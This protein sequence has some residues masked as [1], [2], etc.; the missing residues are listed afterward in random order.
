MTTER[1]RIDVEGVVQGVGF[2]PFVYRLARERGL[3]GWV[4]N[5]PAGVGIEVQG[6]RR[7]IRDFLQQL[8]A[9]RP[10]Q[11]EIHRISHHTTATEAPTGF[12]IRHSSAG[13]MPTASVPV[14]L[15]P[16]ADCLRELH[17]P[18]DRRYRY[19]FI[20][21]TQCGPRFSIIRQLPYDR[22]N[23]AMAGFALCAPCRADYEDPAN[24]RFHAEP[25]ACPDCGP[26]LA[27]L[28]CRGARQASGEAALET[29]AA[30]L[31]AGRI[32]ALKG[33]GGFQPAPGA[34]AS[35]QRPRQ[36]C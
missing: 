1:C 11:A 36:H 2:R 21:C 28:D 25:I 31:E 27:L 18:G 22:A 15:A 13:D 8:T 10:P 34:A 20:N 35:C 23:T 6:D 16:C 17:D 9:A 3:H 14:D 12:T 32:V 5:S 4:A 30:A 24:R 7:Q 19:P 29:A 26:Q 33:V